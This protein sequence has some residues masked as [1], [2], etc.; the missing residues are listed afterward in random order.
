MSI[1][2]EDASLH[3]LALKIQ[4]RLLKTNSKIFSFPPHMKWD[5]VGFRLNVNSQSR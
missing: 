3:Y 4:K 1:L 5:E 2:K